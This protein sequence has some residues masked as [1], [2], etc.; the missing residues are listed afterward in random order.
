M[1]MSQRLSLD[2]QSLRSPHTGTNENTLITVTEQILDLQ[3]SA[4]GGVRT[5]LNADLTKLCFITLQDRLWKTECRNTILQHTAD[6]ISGI[7]DRHTISLFCQ[8]D[9][10]R[11]SCRTCANNCHFLAILRLAR[12]LHFIKI[13]IGNIIFNAADV[14]RLAFASQNTMS[15]TLVSMVTHQGTDHGHRVILKQ[16]LPGLI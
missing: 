8:Q 10:N 4:N 13:S 12:N 3:C 9:R 7:K 11:N 15:L 1:H 6:L 14:Y 16:H 2:T 5:N